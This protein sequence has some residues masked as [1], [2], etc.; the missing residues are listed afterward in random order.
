M[1]L[2]FFKEVLFE[3]FRSTQENRSLAV[4]L[5]V[6]TESEHVHNTSLPLVQEQAIE[7]FQE[8]ALGTT[9]EHSERDT[10]QEPRREFRK[11]VC[12]RRNFAC[13][14]R[15]P[16]GFSCPSQGDYG[17]RRWFVRVEDRLGSLELQASVVQQGG[18]FRKPPLE[19]PSS[20][21]VLPDLTTPGVSG[22]RGVA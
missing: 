22:G 17:A 8:C 9:P 1:L 6:K 3:A 21:L 19:T 2:R 18:S 11:E 4:G 7:E 16:G 5:C 10:V 20:L 15:M 13:C 12:A 14:L